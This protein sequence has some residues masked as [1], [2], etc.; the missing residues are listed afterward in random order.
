MD[1]DRLVSM[2]NRIATFFESMPDEEA[3]RSGVREHLGKYWAPVM[4][5]QPLEHMRS[6][7]AG[8]H[9]LAP[10]SARAWSSRE[11]CG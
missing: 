6:G 1:V 8:L 9:P 7:G 3:A 11:G 4:R 5:A 2:A 10:V